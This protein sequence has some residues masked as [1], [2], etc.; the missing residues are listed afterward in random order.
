V[1]LGN[2]LD[3]VVDHFDGGLVVDRVRR[4]C[5]TGRPSFCAGHLSGMPG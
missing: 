5:D 1:L 2:D 4:T 3:G